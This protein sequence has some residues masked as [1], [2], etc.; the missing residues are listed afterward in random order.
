MIE[1]AGNAY[2]TIVGKGEKD[3]FVFFVPEFESIDSSPKSSKHFCIRTPLRS[4]NKRLSVV[5]PEL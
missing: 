5:T 4:T 1:W 2:H 3:P